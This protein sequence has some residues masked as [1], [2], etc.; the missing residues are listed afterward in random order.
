MIAE[1]VNAIIEVSQARGPA[2]EAQCGSADKVV[3]QPHWPSGWITARDTMMYSL[4]PIARPELET[5]APFSSLTE[6]GNAERS[7]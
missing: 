3:H 1:H 6:V 2:P 7:L 4:V 5:F